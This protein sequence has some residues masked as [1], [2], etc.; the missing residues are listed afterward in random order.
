MDKKMI[1]VLIIDDEAM[2]RRRVY[3]LISGNEFL[4]I[5]GEC[6]S[7]ADA[8]KQITEKQPDLVYLDI[9]LMDMTGFDV[10]EAVPKLIMP[11]VIFVTAYEQYAIDAFNVFS[12]DFLLK[13]VEPERFQR[14]LINALKVLLATPAEFEV[15]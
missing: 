13:P 2:A 1:R 14:S 15:A 10:L 3:E 7:G 12:F 8:I 6:D 4:E 5:V 11:M 9:Q